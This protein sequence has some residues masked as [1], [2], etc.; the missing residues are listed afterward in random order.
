MVNF[1]YFSIQVNEL[2]APVQ[3]ENSVSTDDAGGQM[4]IAWRYQNLRNVDS[5]PTNTVFGHNFDL[6]K[7]IDDELLK[8]SD[9]SFWNGT[10]GN[11]EREGKN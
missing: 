4:T 2:P 1:S 5:S 8:K 10:S 9:I 7:V 6:K 11:V 3:P